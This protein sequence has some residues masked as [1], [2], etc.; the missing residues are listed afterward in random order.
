VIGDDIIVTVVDLRGDKVRLGIA[1][2]K[3]VRVDRSEVRERIDEERRATQVAGP[4]CG[5]CGSRR[6]I[7]VLGPNGGSETCACPVCRP[8]E[9]EE[10]TG[11]AR[12]RR[13]GA[14]GGDGRGRAPA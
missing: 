10:E 14:A 9:F 6:T 8:E 4:P 2:P 5:F 1:A 12:D 7:K 13:L 11:A 3:D